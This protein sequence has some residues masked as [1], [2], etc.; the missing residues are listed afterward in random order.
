VHELG[1]SARERTGAVRTQA[2]AHGCRCRVRDGGPHAGTAAP[3]LLA[4]VMVSF[5]LPRHGSR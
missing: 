1:Y 4:S 2:R 5:P 3:R